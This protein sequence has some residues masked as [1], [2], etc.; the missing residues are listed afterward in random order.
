[1]CASAPDGTGTQ[2]KSREFAGQVKLAHKTILALCDVTTLI[3]MMG[4]AKVLHA[5][6]KE[7][8]L[9][10]AIQKSGCTVPAAEWRHR[11]LES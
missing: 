1:M 5:F 8:R 9:Y 11:L 10:M 3:S 7:E 4:I 2:R 6:A